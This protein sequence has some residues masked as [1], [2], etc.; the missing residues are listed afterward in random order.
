MVLHGFYI[1]NG[2]CLTVILF[3]IDGYRLFR[4]RYNLIDRGL[5][6][7]AIS[8]I[9]HKQLSKIYRDDAANIEDDEIALILQSDS[10]PT[11]DPLYLIL[12]EIQDTVRSYY[13]I[14]LSVSVGHPCGSVNEIRD[15]YKSAQ[16]HAAA[17]LFLGHG[18]LT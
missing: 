13:Q 11:K 15:S 14:S 4:E 17:R 2:P 3:K 6:R 12:G 5:I 10:A 1:F 8:N 7:F 16:H 18:C 9:A